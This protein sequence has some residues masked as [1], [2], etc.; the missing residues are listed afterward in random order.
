MIVI[1]CE[2][3]N[4]DTGWGT[5][6]NHYSKTVNLFE[7]VI[8]ICNKKN[9]KLKIKQY[10]ILHNSREYIQN[11]I[12]IIQDAFKIKKLISKINHQL[13]FHVVVEP[14]ALLV[15]FL[16]KNLYRVYITFAG[17]FFANLAFKEKFIIKFLFKQA[18]KLSDKAIFISIYTKKKINK[19]LQK[20]NKIKT[21]VLKMSIDFIKR[22]P[23]IKKNKTFNILCLSAIKERKGQ[24]NLIKSIKI[25]KKKT[26]NFKVIFAGLV[27]EQAYYEKLK[28]EI[29]KSGLSKKI[30]FK[31][32]VDKKEKHKLFKK[33]DL[34]VLL[35]E[36]SKKGF[37]G[38]GLVYLE[39][40]SYGLPTIV[41][42]QS[43]CSEINF[44][45]STGIVVN[46][47]N[48]KKISKFIYSITKK[49][50]SKISNRCIEIASKKDWKY[51]RKEIEKLYK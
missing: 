42:S 36:D 31:G 2:N 22:K 44:K 1:V 30:E 39:A 3:L 41:S 33:S 25:L 29:S 4:D 9:K 11:P 21:S 35:S 20:I 38:Y 7:N 45:N 47:R 46:P 10:D 40:L 16:K 28:S 34:F 13:T 37:E 27:Y 12:R 48:Y 51:R 26:E 15:P 18:L 6:A 50:I 32:F 14:Y 23:K 8:I 19:D 43:G 17:S 49:D 24:L 5:Y